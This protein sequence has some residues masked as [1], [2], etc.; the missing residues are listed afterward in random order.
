MERS[1]YFNTGYYYNRQKVS[2]KNSMSHLL[3]ACVPDANDSAETLKAYLTGTD[4]SDARL[5]EAAMYSPEWIDIVGEYLGWDGFTAGCCYFMAHMNE[6]FDDKRKAMIARFTPLEVDELN[7]GAFDRTWFTE[8]YERLG[9]KRFQLIY[10]AAKYISDGAKHTRARKYAD[11]ALGKYDEPELMAEIEA[12][13]NKDLLMAVGILPIENEEQIKDRYMFL[14]KF[15]KESRQF[16]AQRRASEAAA[17]ST[18]MRNMA[19]NAG[20]QD[21]T[22]LT[23]RMESLVVQG[24]R[25]YF[26]PHEVEEV[27]VWLEMEDGGKCTVICEKNGKQLKSVPAKIKKDEYVLALMDAKKQMAEQSRRT[28]A[29]LED[30]MESQEEYTWAEI[31]GMLE[32]PVIYDMVAALVFKVAE[33]DGVKAELDN[34]ADSIMSGANEL[35]DS[36]NVVLGFATEDGFNTFVATS[37]GDADIADTVSKSTENN[38]SKKT[39]LNLMNLSDDTKLTVAHPFHMYMAG[40]WHDIQKYVFDNKIVQPFKQVFRELYVKTEE[41]MNMEHSLRYAGNQIQPK[42][43]LG[44]LRSR[45][46][47]ADI[48]DGLQK[49]YYKENIVAQI[50]ALADWFSPADIESPTLEWV[51]FSDRKTGKNMRIKD[52]P[53]II[54]S[55]VMRDVDM[56]VSVAH[57]GGVDPETSHSTVEMR[58]AIA[59]FTMPL[60]R[61]TNV[62]F[63]KNHAVIEGKRANYTVHLGS[64]VV[65]QEAGPM[66]NVLPVHSQRRGR[67]FLPFVDDDPKTSEVLTKILFF[68]EDNKIKDPYILGQIE[69]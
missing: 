49:V 43:T 25:E 2:K 64:G 56:A 50:Y 17:V 44:C 5:I 20:Y 58:K 33:P 61:L 27:T 65:H 37:I 53:D 15:K 42:K 24:M 47:V 3:Q 41:E 13:R 9:D 68:A 16:G 67:I 34:A 31:R 14:Q 66:I 35:D 57:A 32:N 6:S 46:W 69:Q 51:V 60:F 54:F 55:E 48:E 23:L 62:T 21:V 52:I 39:G 12:K 26:Q 11:A 1:T 18:A 63:T 19:I 22:R 36:K 30:A 29:M 10:K 45:H 8:V 40:K 59:E 4:I 7:D 28:K 38:S